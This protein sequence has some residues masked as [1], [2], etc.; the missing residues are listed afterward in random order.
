MEL[1][2][3]KTDEVIDERA[4]LN[5]KEAIDYAKQIAQGLWA[6]HKMELY[7]EM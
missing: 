2:D 4:P 1:V 6:A 5:Y 3:G 7:T